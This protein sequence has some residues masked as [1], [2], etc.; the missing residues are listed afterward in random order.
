MYN[1]YIHVDMYIHIHMHTCM[2]VYTNKLY[3]YV[4][5]RAADLPLKLNRPYQGN[6]GVLNKTCVNVIRTYTYISSAIA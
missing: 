6:A 1:M 3:V 5:V 2:C 4:C